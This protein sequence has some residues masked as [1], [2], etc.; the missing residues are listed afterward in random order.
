MLCPGIA[1]GASEGSGVFID[2]FR[3]LAVT[4]ACLLFALAG[5]NFAATSAEARDRAP[6]AKSAQAK[7]A[8]ANK[9][10][11]T[12][13]RAKS[14]VPNGKYT[15]LEGPAETGSVE[16][17]TSDLAPNCARSRKQLFVEGQGWM[18]RKVT[19]CY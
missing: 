19:T 2:R 17:P 1:L 11:P 13:A 12:L 8:P 15:S 4:A 5:S 10:S 6:T 3:K 16:K 7:A 18:V 9:A 14:A